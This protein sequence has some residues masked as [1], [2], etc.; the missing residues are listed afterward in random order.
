MTFQTRVDLIWLSSY[1]APSEPEIS[2]C[3]DMFIYS[4]HCQFCICNFETSLYSVQIPRH[5]TLH[6]GS[7]PPRRFGYRKS[8][9]SKMYQRTVLEVHIF[10]FPLYFSFRFFLTSHTLLRYLFLCLSVVLWQLVAK[11]VYLLMFN[12]VFVTSEDNHGLHK[13]G[14]KI[15]V[16]Q[17]KS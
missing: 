12:Y 16:F 4:F 6:R 8:H 11:S 10:Y 13:P 1:S 9:F 5:C 7:A 14:R 2:L 15:P 17:Y 3:M